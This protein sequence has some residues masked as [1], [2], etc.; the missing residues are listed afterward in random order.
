MANLVQSLRSAYRDGKPLPEF[1]SLLPRRPTI[2]EVGAHD[3]STTVGFRRL[4]PRARILAFEP[5]PRAIAKFRARAELRDVTL[6]ECAVADRGGQATFHQCSGR[7]PGYTGDDWDASGSI[8]KPTGVIT[9][10]P[11]MTFDREITIQVVRLDDVARNIDA[12][13]LIWADVQGA[14]EDLIRGAAETLKRTRFFYT[15]CLESGDYDGQIGLSEIC[16]LLPE[17]E[18]VEVFAYDVLFRNAALPQARSW[19]PR[20]WWSYPRQAETSKLPSSPD[21]VFQPPAGT[22]ARPF[23]VLMPSAGGAT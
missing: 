11:W 20:S 15:E 2:I 7:P 14:E 10:Y 6:L 9:A 3:G 21:C 13:D 23:A 22:F 19:W 1:K 5:E 16:A 17:F 18:I 4:F 12:I 8:R